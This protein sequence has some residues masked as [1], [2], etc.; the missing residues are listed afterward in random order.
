MTKVPE[1]TEGAADS[2][3]VNRRHPAL[4]VMAALLKGVHVRVDGEEYCYGNG[5][6]SIRRTGYDLSTGEDTDVFID[7]QMTVGQFIQWCE[8]IP[9]EAVIQ[10]VFGSVMSDLRK[11]RP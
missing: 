11:R 3:K 5:I 9:E 8:R 2:V 1:A 4:L 10:V 6:L 7:T